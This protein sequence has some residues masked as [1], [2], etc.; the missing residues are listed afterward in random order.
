MQN[1]LYIVI[2]C[3]N[4]GESL[5]TTAFAVR[6]KLRGFISSGDVNEKSRIMFVNDGSSD[7]TWEVI[8]GLASGDSIFTG[9]SL[10]GNSGEDLAYFAGI[11]EAAKHADIIITKDSDLQDDINAMDKMLAEYKNGA[12]IVFGVRESRK[13]ERL[14]TRL[15]SGGFYKIMTTAGARVIPQ[16]SHFRLMSRRAALALCATKEARPFLPALAP[17]LG[18]KSAVVYHKRTANEQR[19]SH[20]NL[21]RLFALAFGA[22]I[23]YTSAPVKLIGALSLLSFLTAICGFIYLIVKACS[24]TFSQTTLLFSCIWLALAI[25]LFA[26]R[27]I[28]EYILRVSADVRGR[29]RF[30]I[31]ENLAEDN[32]DI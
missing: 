9:I 7:C 32:N 21:K 10:A 27:I 25:T 30:I 19:P 28:G 17:G 13:N 26:L 2:P 22:I 31:G 6:D 20:Y 12:E 4:E 8:K 1:T 29:P 11:E 15:T 18:F 3:Y 24:G 14:F 16:H 5:R 23:G